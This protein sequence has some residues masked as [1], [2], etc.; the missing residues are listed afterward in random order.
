MIHETARAGNPAIENAD[1]PEYRSFE[2]GLM[3]VAIELA[4]GLVRDGEGASKFV[5]VQVTGAAS[6]ATAKASS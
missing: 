3:A 2:E 1:T 6:F 5:T 4:Q